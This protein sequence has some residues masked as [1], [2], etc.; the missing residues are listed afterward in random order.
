M[1]TTRVPFQF[2]CQ[3]GAVTFEHVHD[4]PR[5]LVET[6]GAHGH[7]SS[8]SCQSWYTAIQGIMDE[9]EADCLRHSSP[10]CACGLP[11]ITTSQMPMSFLE[12]ASPRMVV[13]VEQLCGQEKCRTQARQETVRMMAGPRGPDGS[14]QYT[15]PLVVETVMSCKVCAKAEGVRKCGRCRAVAYCGREHQ[16]QDWPIHKA[17][18]IPWAE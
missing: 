16:K 17:G 10:V 3:F 6:V 8:E 14:P 15:D 12:E 13:I 18:C 11:A 2:L 4:L 9:H 1:A 7:P 5:S